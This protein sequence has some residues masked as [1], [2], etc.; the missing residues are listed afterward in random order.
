V[1]EQS[2]KAEMSAAIRGDFQR[3]RAR[4]VSAA[5]VPQ[6]E[7]EPGQEPPV[8]ETAPPVGPAEPDEPLAEPAPAELGDEPPPR[9]GWLSRLSGR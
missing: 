1:K 3:L 4:G 9:R 5:L 7:A 6:D 2:H 8:V